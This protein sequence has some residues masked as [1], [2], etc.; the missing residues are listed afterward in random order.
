MWLT[1]RVAMEQ[2][3]YGENGFYLRERPSGHFRTSVGASPV[4]A[5]AVLRRLVAVD[6][7]LGNPPVVDLVDVGAGEGELAAGVLAAAPPGLR[8]RLRVTGVDLASRPLPLPAE[9]R[10]AHAVPGGVRGLV[11]ANEWLD[12]VPLDVAEQ[13][14]DGPRLVM[15]DPASGAERLGDS[16]CDAD[17]AWLARWWPMHSPGERAEIGRPRDEA[18]ASVIVRLAAGEAV[19]IDY[20]HFQAGR[21]PYGTLTGYR[22]GSLVPPV[23]D[24]SC[25]ITAHVALDACAAAG[26]RAGA[27]GARDAGAE[28][29]GDAGDVRGVGGVGGVGDAGGVG[30]VGGVGDVRGVGG[31]GDVGD[32]EGVGAVVTTL[33][34]QRRALLDLGVTG[35]RPPVELARTDPRGYLQA[36]TRASQ[37]AE[38]IATGGLGDFGW[39]VQSRL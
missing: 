28:T 12:N 4:F 34:T 27:T 35:T 22:D 33:T 13:T 6:D 31:V 37:E 39:L 16:P 11:I 3:L 32:A 18:W 1:W 10:W 7:A 20:A 23:P 14:A 5:E 25:D 30:G 17:L 24:G 9:I 2:A 36:L 26:E 38:L 8:E 29:T 15:V 21:P 19:A